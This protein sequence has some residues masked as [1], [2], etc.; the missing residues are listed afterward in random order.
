MP[1]WHDPHASDLPACD[2]GAGEPWQ[3]EHD[4]T[5]VAR[6]QLG[7]GG[8]VGAGVTDGIGVGGAV[9]AGVT[10]GL[11][12]GVAPGAGVIVGLGVGVG[13]ALSPQLS[14][15]WQALAQERVSALHAGSVTSRTPFMCVDGLTVVVV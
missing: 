1:L 7:A 11:G 14:E 13:P 8:T 9:G 12:V 3:V 5:A 4:A 15:P 10:D 6:V 2:A